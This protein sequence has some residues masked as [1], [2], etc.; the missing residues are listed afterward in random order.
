MCC[1]HQLLFCKSQVPT[2]SAEQLHEAHVESIA[3]LAAS[4]PS[5]TCSH[6]YQLC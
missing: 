5:L 1:D 3:A 6:L 2:L 4:L